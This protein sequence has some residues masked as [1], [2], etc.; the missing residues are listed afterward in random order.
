M[1]GAIRLQEVRTLYLE[2]R[3]S[4]TI[5]IFYDFFP[6]LLCAFMLALNSPRV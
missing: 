4:S 5:A 2:E 6:L 3:L 1:D